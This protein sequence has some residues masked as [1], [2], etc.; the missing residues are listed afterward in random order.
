VHGA[1]VDADPAPTA[2]SPRY[3]YRAF[4]SYSHQDRRWGRR[5]LRKL[6]SYRVPQRLVGKPSAVGTVPARLAPVFRD[7]D[8]LPTSGDLGQEIRQAL[9]ES[10]ALIVICSPVAARSRWVNQEILEYRR[11]G[12][13][14]R[15]FC[16]VVDGEPGSGGE[17][18]ALPP[19]VRFQLDARGEL[20]EEPLE[21]AAADAREVGDGPRR[22]FRRL[23]AGLLGIG[24]DALRRRELAR[25]QRR[26]VA[27]AA[28]SLLGMAVTLA[29]AAA[30]YLARQDAERR[31]DQAERLV[32]FMVGDLRTKLEAVGRLDVLDSIGDESM[33]YFEG[34][35][36]EDITDESLALQARALTQIGEV[37][38][39]QGRYLKAETAF[40]EAYRRSAELA[41]R[42][43]DDGDR[44]FDRGQAEFWIGYVGWRR[45]NLARAEDWL[46]RYLETSTQLVDLDGERRDWVRELAYAEHNLAVIQMDRDA[47]A[48][49]RT[50][51]G[52]E[53]DVLRGLIESDPDDASLWFDLADAH[54]WQGSAAERLGD[55]RAAREYFAR[56]AEETRRALA[57]APEQ[58]QWRYDLANA[59]A[60]EARVASVL[61]LVDEAGELA[62]NAIREF[63]I[64]VEHDS[65]NPLWRSYLAANTLLRAQ[66]QAAGGEYE[67]AHA[68]AVA[69]AA[70]V[71]DL[72]ALEDSDVTWRRYLAAALLT[73]ASIRWRQGDAAA[74]EG[75][76]E[77]VPG[78]LADLTGDDAVD[79]ESTVSLEGKASL[80]L[81][82]LQ[83]ARGRHD[84]ATAHWEEGYARLS[85]E[86]GG[87]GYWQL[88]DPL[89]RLARRTGR[90]EVADEIVTELTRTGYVPLEPWP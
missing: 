74:A 63:E 46:Q 50:T 81:G 64:L 60:H 36:P 8:E 53:V 40:G 13:S 44:L 54:S 29:L 47:V 39:E 48:T 3:R 26:L 80:L 73:A 22:A 51:F 5:L 30:A 32:G 18:E 58:V 59:E 56:Q 31:R 19:A 10:E 2:G 76:L 71:A 1:A 38:A 11:L 62:E 12:R 6:E 78:L 77:R 27:I 45:G 24:Y 28:A 86:A 21:P 57:L 67:T 9:V 65:E 84:A 70:T 37:R 88:L 69:A 49:A 25:R 55:L 83:A 17:R 33:Q 89:A 14:D 41:A 15:V 23:T 52:R 68:G 90:V 79:R 85:H 61:G 72:V 43:P 7:R 4:L 35:E 87:S 75:H 82:D 20:T 42:A 34:L 66:L 16:F